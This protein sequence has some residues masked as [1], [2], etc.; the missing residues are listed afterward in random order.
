MMTATMDSA[1]DWTPN[2]KLEMSLFA[3]AALGLGEMLGSVAI[4][5]IIDRYG[6]KKGVL[7]T[8]LNLTIA[9]VLLYAYIGY[10]KFSVLTF[11]VTFFWGFQDSFLNNCLNCVYGF[12]FDSNVQPFSVG[13]LV[14][15]LTVFLFML[16]QSLIV[17]R[18]D[19]IVYFSC[20]F[21]FAYFALAVAYTFEFRGKKKEGLLKNGD[22]E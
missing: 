5:Q 2:K 3:M 16:L 4:G 10:Y 15:S 18:A 9:V 11:F 21:A 7:A 6:I 8:A 22:L 14:Q 20:C 1:L 17:S 19:Y 12:E 13:A